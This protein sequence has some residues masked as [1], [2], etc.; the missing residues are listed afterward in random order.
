MVMSAT[1]TSLIGLTEGFPYLKEEVLR[2]E[3]RPRVEGERVQG[4]MV[5]KYT[6]DLTLTQR[7]SEKGRGV[8]CDNKAKDYKVWRTTYI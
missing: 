7:D 3:A 1:T 2:D 5:S 4:D 8:F 6:S